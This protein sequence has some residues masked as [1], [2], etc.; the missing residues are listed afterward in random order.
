MGLS[1]NAVVSWYTPV[2]MWTIKGWYDDWLV[3]LRGIASSDPHLPRVCR[4]WVTSQFVPSDAIEP[5]AGQCQRPQGLQPRSPTCGWQ[6]LLAVHRS[7]LPHLMPVIPSQCHC[8][9]ET[10]ISSDT[11]TQREGE[12][13]THVT[14]RKQKQAISKYHIS[15]YIYTYYI[16]IYIYILCLIMSVYIRNCDMLKKRLYIRTHGSGN[17][18]HHRATLNNHW[19]QLC[20]L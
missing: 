18:G 17:S 20:G 13:E 7:Y 14:V 15:D 11:H 6:Q 10:W 3:D 9:K 8:C 4:S 19:L 16:F 12:R 1:E 5:T 2:Y